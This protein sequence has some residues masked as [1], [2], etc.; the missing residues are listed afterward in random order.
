[1][2]KKVEIFWTEK[3]K[4]DLRDI[5][6]FLVSEIEEKKAFSIIQIISSRTSQLAL[7]PE[8]GSLEP[9]LLHL[10]RPYRRLIEGNYEIIYRI[11]NDYIYI[12][13]IFDSRQNPKKIKVK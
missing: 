6:N 2:E 11:A 1:M 12:N 8:S 4:S 9:Y 5:Y 3:A 10:K 13:R 7:F